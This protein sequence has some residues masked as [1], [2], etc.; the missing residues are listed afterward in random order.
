MPY[1]KPELLRR[2]R[3][4]ACI[5]RRSVFGMVHQGR[6]K[7]A[8]LLRVA[9]AMARGGG[10]A[11]HMTPCVGRGVFPDVHSECL[12]RWESVIA[13]YYDMAAVSA[14]SLPRMLVC[15]L[16]LCQVVRYPACLLVSRR[17]VMLSRRSM[18]C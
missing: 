11:V 12:V 6:W 16:I 5:C 10:L 14:M 13:S 3:V 1:F 18:W 7:V 15:P 8:Q 9:G 17:S 4:N 2:G